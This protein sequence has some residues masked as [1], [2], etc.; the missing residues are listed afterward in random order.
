M[1]Y[2][3]V[4]HK[5][6]RNHEVRGGYLWS[7]IRNANGRRNQSYDNMSLAQPGDIVFSYADGRIGAIGQVVA[8]ASLS[9]KP[10]EFGTVGDYWSNEGWL[11]DVQFSEASHSIRPRDHIHAIGSLLPNIYSPIQANGHG[12]QGIYLAAISDALGELLIRLLRMEA[13]PVFS[14]P[15]PEIPVPDESLLADLRDIARTGHIPETQRIQL[16]K[17]RVGQG[18]FRKQVML[19]G[20][21]CRVTGVRDP[22][23]LIASHIKPWKDSSNEERLNGYNGIMLSPHIDALFDS[24]LISFE[25]GGEMLVHPTL[26][27]EILDRWSLPR[28]TCVERFLP[29]QA[30]F[31]DHHRHVFAGLAI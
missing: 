26:P 28:D 1:A 14:A 11:V 19:R 12:N 10:T 24:H 18:L 29:E 2:W 30:K 9:P 5:Q 15:L 8:P 21:I 25:L 6:T 23:L 17:A 13:D 7:P 16:S 4:N 22:R 27:D 31:L 20:P 3:W